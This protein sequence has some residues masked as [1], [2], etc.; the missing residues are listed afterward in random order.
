MKRQLIVS[1]LLVCIASM[2]IAPTLKAQTTVSPGVKLDD[3]YWYTTYGTWT[4]I[5]PSSPAPNIVDANQTQA[6]E[7]RISTINGTVVNTFTASYYSSGNPE[8]GPGSIDLQTGNETGTPW[9]AIIGANLTTG[10]LIHPSGLDGITINDTTTFQGRPADEII[11]SFY[12]STT[13]LTDTTDRLFDQQTGM[14]V[15]EVDTEIDD[16]SVS[17]STSTSIL[18]TL[19]YSSPWDPASASALNALI[20]SATTTN[21]GS[22]STTSTGNSGSSGWI[23]DVTIAAV[24]IVVAGVVAFLFMR[25]RRSIVRRK[26]HTHLPPP[27]PPPPQ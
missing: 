16:G 1:L 10:D 26:P 14:L 12:N 4:S 21:N 9:P 24:V 5:P 6:I 20:T 27:P 22:T 2:V 25:S 17:G 8:A 13:G 7:V 23:Y 19:I 18:T 15:K 3:D 11:F